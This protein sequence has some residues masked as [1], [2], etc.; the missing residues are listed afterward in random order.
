MY[1]DVVSVGAVDF[2]S[3]VAKFS[4][5][6]NEVDLAAPGD[7]IWSTLP[8]GKY[9][10]LSGTSM[11]CPHVAGMA[12]LYIEKY[13]RRFNKRP[14]EEELYLILK[15]MAKDIGALGIEADTGAGLVS[16]WL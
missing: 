9:G 12:A 4:N 15:V 1:P 13:G 3:Q 7:H 10:A 2:S 11:A 16:A 8:D 6:N 14:S 5:T